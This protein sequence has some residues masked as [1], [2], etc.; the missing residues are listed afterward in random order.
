MAPPTRDRLKSGFPRASGSLDAPLAEI[1]EEEG[2][3][4]VYLRRDLLDEKQDAS[5][6]T[7]FQRAPTCKEL[8]SLNLSPLAALIPGILKFDDCSGI[9]Q[10][11]LFIVLFSA[12]NLLS[13]LVKFVFRIPFTPPK[14]EPPSAAKQ[15]STALDLAMLGIAIWGAV[16]TFPEAE[17]LAH[18]GGDQCSMWMFVT[19]FCCAAITAAVVVVMLLIGGGC[20]CMRA[21]SERR[22]KHEQDLFA[23]RVAGI[24]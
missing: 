12:T 13:V 9:P 20:C 4:D 24:Q 21:Y 6:P 15:L 10:L 16:L 11:T 14:D 18:N 2:T 23:A 17:R 19:A 5:R 7:V 1:S 3:I 8:L 22:N